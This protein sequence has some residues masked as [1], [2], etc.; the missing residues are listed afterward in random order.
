MCR[1]QKCFRNVILSNLYLNIDSRTILEFFPSLYAF[2]FVKCRHF[3]HDRSCLL[4]FST[5]QLRLTCSKHEKAYRP[6]DF[7]QFTFFRKT[8]SKHF[9]VRNPLK[10]M[11]HCVL[12]IFY[13]VTKII[14]CVFLG[15]SLVRDVTSIFDYSLF[16]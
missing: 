7:K 9:C 6:F 10:L 8:L 15:C 1:S 13:C 14:M 2:M 5:G 12:L 16:I 11:T 4:Q 3:R